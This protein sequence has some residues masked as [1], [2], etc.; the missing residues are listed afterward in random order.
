MTLL[1]LNF[2][3][4]K[5]RKEAQGL[6][7]KTMAESR[8]LTIPEQVHFDSLTARIQELDAAIVRRESLRKAF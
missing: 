7:D 4:R 6:L 1:E 5:A 2:Q 3:R 8:S